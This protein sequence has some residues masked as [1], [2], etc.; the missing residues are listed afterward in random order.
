MKLFKKVASNRDERSQE[1]HKFLR[2]TDCPRRYCWYWH[3]L[4]LDLDLPVT[5][6]CEVSERYP[7]TPYDRICC[8]ASGNPDHKDYYEP[9]EPH[10]REDGFPE[11][12]FAMTGKKYRARKYQ[13]RKN[14][15]KR[16]ST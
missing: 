5:A 1:A 9:R 13:R 6:G 4:S 7:G 14:G 11:D 15:P 8:R 16:P 12:Y 2:R 10:L 3:T